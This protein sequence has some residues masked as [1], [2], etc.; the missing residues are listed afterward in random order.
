[1]KK[2]KNLKSQASSKETKTPKKVHKDGLGEI[3]NPINTKFGKVVIW[4][5]IALM[6]LLPIIALIWVLVDRLS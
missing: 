3:K 2:T 1:M 5:L 6:G 4:L